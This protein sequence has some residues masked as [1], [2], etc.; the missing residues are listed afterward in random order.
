M[1]KFPQHQSQ[2]QLTEVGSAF[3]PLLFLV[4][5]QDSDQWRVGAPAPSLIQAGSI[6]APLPRFEPCR[7]DIVLALVW[8]CLQLSTNATYSLVCNSDCDPALVPDRHLFCQLRGAI[9]LLIKPTIIAN[10]PPSST[11]RLSSVPPPCGFHQKSME[12]GS[13]CS[14]KWL[15]TLWD[16]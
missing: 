10:C 16:L 15:W 12:E 9:A 13:P 7:L 14:C 3:F 5:G 2:L 1:S 6:T 8:C 11:S 4:K